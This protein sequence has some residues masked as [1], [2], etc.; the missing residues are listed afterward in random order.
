MKLCLVNPP[1]I[2][3]YVSDRD[4]AGGIGVARPFQASWRTPYLPPTPPQDLLYAAAIA[5]REQIPVAFVDGIAGRLN[6]EA[7]A[8]DVKAEA[9]THIG[10]RVS[11]PSLEEDLAMADRLKAENPEARVFLFGHASQ[12]TYTKWRTQTQADAVF[13][14]EVEALLMPY[15]SGEGHANILVPSEGAK[16]CASWA[17]VED[18]DALPF[19]AWHLVDIPAYSRSGGVEDFVFYI[20]TSRGCP[21]GCSMCPY[22]VHQGKQWRF[23]SIDNVMAEF[24]YL[25]GLGARYIQTRDPNISWRKPHL[26]AIAER[27][28]GE[29]QFRIS[30]ETD[31]EVLNES[32]LI[33]LREAGFVRIM[34]GVESVDE[35]VL[36]D[37]RQNANAL[38]RSLANMELCAKLGIQVTGFFI[39]GSLNETWQSV[40]NTVATARILPIDYSVSLMTPYFGTVMRDEFIEKG[41]YK[42]NATFKQYN[43]YTGIIRT[44]GLSF[45][46]VTLAHAWASAEL[47]LVT[48][49]RQLAKAK[50]PK[51][52][53]IQA[54]RV[55]KQRF[56]TEGLRAKA[57]ARE[58]Q[59]QAALAAATS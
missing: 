45:E 35:A 57:A 7:V 41:F 28:K 8:L 49:E 47:E 59:N 9:P 38:K 48:R 43:G 20:L 46:E 54:A 33:A 53:A 40:R 36:K 15:L 1:E 10:V 26:L 44:E 37:I 13:Y 14:G 58:K 50:G 42:D 52:R 56:L 39:V 18:L 30:T 27:L 24:E 11:M 55:A 19:P 3:G 17:Y 5:E 21:K 31:L 25:R 34:T 6:A 29:T 51:A 22:Y 2:A 16:F 12:T 23:R 4:K 32:D